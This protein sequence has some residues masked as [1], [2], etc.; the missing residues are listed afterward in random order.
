MNYP[1][2]VQPLKYLARR[3]QRLLYGWMKRALERRAMNRCLAGIERLEWALP[4]MIVA[5]CA[6]PLVLGR[7]ILSNLLPAGQAGHVFGSPSI[8]LFNALI[9][10][11]VLIGSWMVLHSFI[12]HRGEI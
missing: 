10:L 9:G 11:K 12:R 5:V 1:I 7:P 3:E 2:M 8:L 4:M 6:L